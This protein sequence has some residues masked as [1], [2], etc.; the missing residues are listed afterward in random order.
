M[1]ELEDK[2]KTILDIGFS[3]RQLC[4]GKTQEGIVCRTGQATLGGPVRTA[5]TG[6]V[7]LNSI[8][9]V[10]CCQSQPTFKPTASL[11][12]RAEDRASRHGGCVVEIISSWA[13][14]HARGRAGEY[15]IGESPRVVGAAK[16]IAQSR[17]IRIEVME[18]QIGRIAGGLGAVD[19]HSRSRNLHRGG[20][21]VRETGFAAC[22]I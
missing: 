2:S 10:L 13:I 5:V 12:R 15:G 19:V 22:L 4:H 20:A 21:E 8:S 3:I 17:R 7:G 16:R 18:Q 6:D 1:L 14:G 11:P 9:I